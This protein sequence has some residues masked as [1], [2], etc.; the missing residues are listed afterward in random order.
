MSEVILY[1]GTFQTT[2]YWA[3]V[4]SG[5][6][7]VYLPTDLQKLSAY[8]GFAKVTYNGIYKYGS[9]IQMSLEIVDL[10][11]IIVRN[12]SQIITFDIQENKTDIEKGI[13]SG[14]YNSINPHDCGTFKLTRE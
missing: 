4:V 2:A 13:I 12:N 11:K 14:S 6:M 1:E 10:K 8:R 9:K 5:S 3:Y 7:S